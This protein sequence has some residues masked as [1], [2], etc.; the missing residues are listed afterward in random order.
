MRT[1]K[2][3]LKCTHFYTF[4]WTSGVDQPPASV[5]NRFSLPPCLHSNAIATLLQAQPLTWTQPAP[6]KPLHLSSVAE[7]IVH[8][9]S[10]HLD[11]PLPLRRACRVHLLKMRWPYQVQALEGKWIFLELQAA[12]CLFWRIR[13]N[14]SERSRV[15]S[16]SSL[17]DVGCPNR[18]AHVHQRRAACI[19]PSWRTHS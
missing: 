9:H 7:R 2:R 1:Q 12:P 16:T 11:W 18:L 4:T 17:R 13:N 19:T 5:I 3:T 10:W 8:Q 6:L 15:K 14:L